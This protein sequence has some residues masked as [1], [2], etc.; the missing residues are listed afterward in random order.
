MSII[1]P[2]F[3]LKLSKSNQIFSFGRHLQNI[4][5]VFRTLKQRILWKCELG[6]IKD[7]PSNI[8]NRSWLPQQAILGNKL[9]VSR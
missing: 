6:T 1:R 5:N 9:R 2:F 7:F 8:M 3:L 4:V